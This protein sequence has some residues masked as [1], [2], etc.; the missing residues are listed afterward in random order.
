MDLDGN[1]KSAYEAAYHDY[2]KK[3]NLNNNPIS[4]NDVYNNPNIYKNS[5][6]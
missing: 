3:N 5:K 6:M 2:N 4:K 1:K